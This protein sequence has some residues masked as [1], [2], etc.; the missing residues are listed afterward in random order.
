VD[1][2]TD[3]AVHWKPVFVADHKHSEGV[4]AAMA[5]AASNGKVHHY[6][7]CFDNSDS[8]EEQ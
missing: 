8:R 2:V 4:D 3:E 7:H 6:E 1:P 5:P